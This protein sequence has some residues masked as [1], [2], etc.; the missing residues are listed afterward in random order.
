[1]NPKLAKDYGPTSL[2]QSKSPWVIAVISSAHFPNILKIGD[3][4]P[5]V[6]C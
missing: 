1:M 2:R 3:A 5:G 6:G 4:W